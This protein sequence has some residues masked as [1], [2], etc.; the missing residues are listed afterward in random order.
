MKSLSLST[1]L[2]FSLCA[3][4]CCPEDDITPANTFSIQNENL[5]S[6]EGN[7]STFNLNDKITIQTEIP[8]NQVDLNGNPIDLKDL[9]YPDI[10]ENAFLEHSITL[11]KETGFGTLS[12]IIVSNSDIENIT[13]TTEVNSEFINVINVYDSDSDSFKSTFSI[14]LKETGT[15]FLSDKRFGFDD[16]SGIRISGGVFELGFVEINTSIQNSNAEGAYE[17]IVNE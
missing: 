11:F 10:L 13:G 17:F 8:N 4:L 3:T 9:F 6:V 1:M 15:F 5:I 16:F 12:E 2:L 14:T 7:F